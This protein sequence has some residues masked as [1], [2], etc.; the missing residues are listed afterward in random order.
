MACSVQGHTG[1]GVDLGGGAAAGVP[2]SEPKDLGDFKS[3]GRGHVALIQ[4][5]GWFVLA[6]HND[7]FLPNRRVIHIEYFSCVIEAP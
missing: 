3:L 5:K 2:T 1:G 6:T 4:T 7:H